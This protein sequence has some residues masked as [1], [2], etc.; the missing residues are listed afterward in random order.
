MTSKMM[1]AV[2]CIGGAR[3]FYRVMLR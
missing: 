1:I 2:L 3:R